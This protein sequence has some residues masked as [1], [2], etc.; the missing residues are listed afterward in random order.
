M[1]FEIRNSKFKILSAPLAGGRDH[2]RRRFAWRVA[3]GSLLGL[4]GLSLAG[5][6]PAAGGDL[7]F[8]ISNV[9]GESVAVE[10]AGRSAK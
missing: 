7:R 6:N 1:S 3:L 8:Q 5:C 4:V 2:K 9:R 10:I